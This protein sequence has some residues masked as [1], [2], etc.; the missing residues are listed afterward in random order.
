[1]TISFFD[2]V[3]LLVLYFFEN[4]VSSQVLLYN[5]I[6]ICALFWVLYLGGG[7]ESIFPRK[8]LRKSNPVFGKIYT[9]KWLCTA[10][11]GYNIFFVSERW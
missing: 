6:F 4:L 2:T 10:V 1:M 11:C 3:L 8:N 5:I 9:H 7:F